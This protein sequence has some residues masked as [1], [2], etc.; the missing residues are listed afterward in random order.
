MAK[1]RTSGMMHVA[2][3]TNEQIQMAV[4]GRSDEKAQGVSFL[5][6]TIEIHERDRERFPLSG[7]F[8]T[9]FTNISAGSD[10]TSISLCSIMYNLFSHPRC[11]E[12]VGFLYTVCLGIPN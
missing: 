1:L 4:K 12:K 8:A 6:K 10:T 2:Q 9:C 5:S 3:F 7:A 11:L